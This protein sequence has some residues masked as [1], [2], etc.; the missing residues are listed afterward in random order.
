MHEKVDLSDF[1]E[2]SE[3]RAVLADLA[4]LAGSVVF[5]W[6]WP[7][8]P[9]TSQLGHHGAIRMI[10]LHGQSCNVSTILPNM[11]A[12][13]KAYASRSSHGKL[14]GFTAEASGSGKG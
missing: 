6:T 2:E 5:G 12:G 14:R 4:D 13:R 7:L 9:R 3:L 1:C 10:P 11:A 8:D